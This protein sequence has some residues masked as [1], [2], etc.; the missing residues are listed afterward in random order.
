MR[1]F[2]KKSAQRASGHHCVTPHGFPALLAPAVVDGVRRVWAT[3][4]QKNWLTP[5]WWASF[6]HGASRS[7]RSVY[8]LGVGG[9]SAR[10]AAS[11]RAPR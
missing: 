4:S 9:G 11:S 1:G 2:Q 7:R 3:S 6:G 10:C 8:A 5:S